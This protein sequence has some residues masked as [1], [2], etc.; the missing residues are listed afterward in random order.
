[1]M[2]RGLDKKEAKRKIVEG[3]FDPMIKKIEVENIRDNV[4]NL[5]SQRL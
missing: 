1:M 3:F 2:S 4:T 5:I